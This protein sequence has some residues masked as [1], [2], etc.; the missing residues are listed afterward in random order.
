MRPLPA[1]GKA[2]REKR[3]PPR[4]RGGPSETLP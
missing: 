1:P 4:R 2:A 3:R